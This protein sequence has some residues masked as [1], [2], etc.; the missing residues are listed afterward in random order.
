MRLSAAIAVLLAAAL[1]A[2]GLGAARAEAE[3]WDCRAAIFHDPDDAYAP[4][5]VAAGRFDS[6]FEPLAELR[7]NLG[8]APGSHW[9]RLSCESHDA[10][11]HDIVV[12]FTYAPLDVVDLHLG[13]DV[14]PRHRVGDMQLF[15]K[16]VLADRL[17]AFPLKIPPFEPLVAYVRTANSG[18]LQYGVET[19][20]ASRYQTRQLHESVLFGAYYG[21]A[22]AVLALNVFLSIWVRERVYVNYAL[23]VAS[24]VIFQ[25]G[26]NGFGFAMAWH[27][28]ILFQNLA[29][30]SASGF[31]RWFAAAFVRD[32]LDTRRQAPYW[33]R[34]VALVGWMGIVLG[35]GVMVGPKGPFNDALAVSGVFTSL[36]FLGVGLTCMWRGYAPAFVYV[37]AWSALVT[38]IFLTSCMDVGLLA[39]NFVTQNAMQIG[40]GIEFVLL[41]VG[42]A[43]RLKDAE[44]ARRAAVERS[45]ELEHVARTREAV[46]TTTRLLAHDV[47]APFSIVNLALLRLDASASSDEIRRVLAQLRPGLRRALTRVDG[48]I[49]DVIE[50]GQAADTVGPRAEASFAALLDECLGEMDVLFPQAHV[51]L[52]YDLTHSLALEVDARRMQRVLTNVVQN[53]LQAMHGRGRLWVK[54]RDAKTPSG[55]AAVEVVVGNTGS[56]VAPSDRERIFEPYFTK[57]KPQGTG[58]GLAIARKV[59]AEHGGAVRCESSHDF[60]TELIFTIAVSGAPGREETGVELPA[61]LPLASGLAQVR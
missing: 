58:L 22:L 6:S 3:P 36:T 56:F 14:L 15:S 35:F 24:M 30:A 61:R 51:E 41:T 57:G 40:S 13:G 20:D 18:W 39:L 25:A 46:L 19:V 33:D 21:L 12:R 27:D 1:A 50:V 16:R 31:A 54:T 5:D 43:Y 34:A 2:I 42:L 8:H 17:P 11:E 55:G 9:I 60:G 23:F 10:L 29:P 48:M 52:V 53:A 38:G 28:S 59:I 47:R 4:A 49:R 37:L 26:V 32:Y 7:V 45:L 44:A